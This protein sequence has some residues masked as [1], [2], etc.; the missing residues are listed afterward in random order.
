[1]RKLLILFGFF[2]TAPLLLF[3]AIGFCLFLSYHKTNPHSALVSAS[4]NQAVAYAALPIT[5]EIGFAK[6]TES[7]ARVEIVRQFFA[8]YKSPLTQFAQNVVTA[9][10][11]Y[12]MDFRYIPAIAMQESTLFR[13]EI[14]GTF[15]CWGFGIYGSKITKFDSYQQAID[16][17]TK[18]LAGDYK[19]KGLVTPEQIMSKYNPSNHNG[20]AQAVTGFM[21]QLQ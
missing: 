4:P 7:D 2:L 19:N 14:P 13:G 15:N 12:G 6:I 8:R 11:Q 3:F 5:Q 1:M 21:T 17:V 16:I 10:D 18:T 9:A 20:W